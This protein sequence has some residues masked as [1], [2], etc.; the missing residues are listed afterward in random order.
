[1]KLASTSASS[2]RGCR[3]AKKRTTRPST[4]A[5]ET[6]ATR[7]LRIAL[8]REACENSSFIGG[9]SV[10]KKEA[11]AE[12]EQGR[13]AGGHNYWRREHPFQARRRAEEPRLRGSQE[14][15]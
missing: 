8:R 11:K 3:V 1:M 4:T 13:Q 2:V 6:M 7:R 5:P 9:S 12:C 10:K 14:S 15:T